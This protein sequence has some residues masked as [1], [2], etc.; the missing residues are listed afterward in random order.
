MSIDTK[1]HPVHNQ[2]INLDPYVLG[3]QITKLE[4]DNVQT[5]MTNSRKVYSFFSIPKF[6]PLGSRHY[7]R[8]DGLFLFTIA[9][10]SEQPFQFGFGKMLY[11]GKIGFPVYLQ[12]Q[13]QVEARKAVALRR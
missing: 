4:R 7:R 2:L 1:H 12:K 13:K 10:W 3:F 9:N 11:D 8:P 6:V 5:T